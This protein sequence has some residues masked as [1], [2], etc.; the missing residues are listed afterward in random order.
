[1]KDEEADYLF[2]DDLREEDFFADDLRALDFL[3]P[4][5]REEEDF[6]LL[7]LVALFAVAISVPLIRA[8]LMRS[9]VACACAH[10]ARS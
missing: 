5:L 6:E 9:R 1:M 2:R 8:S 7:F 4:D 10:F 3:D